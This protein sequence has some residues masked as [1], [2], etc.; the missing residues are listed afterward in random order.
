MN[1]TDLIDEI[2]KNSRLMKVD[3]ENTI[4][5]ALEIIKK[6]VKAGDDV[7]FSGFGTFTKIKRKAR[8]GRNPHTGKEIKIPATVV[9]KFRPGKEFKKVLEE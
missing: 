4:N 2:A 6:Q 3:I 5:K 7:T 8:A 1:K 9:P